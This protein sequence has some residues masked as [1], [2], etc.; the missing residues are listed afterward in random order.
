M[1]SVYLP[2]Q[3]DLETKT[4]EP[5]PILVWALNLGL[6]TLIAMLFYFSS[7]IPVF[8]L[9]W[10][11]RLTGTPESNM[12]IISRVAANVVPTIC[13]ALAL[14]LNLRRANSQDRGLAKLLWLFAVCVFLLALNL[15]AVAKFIRGH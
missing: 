11:G 9:F 13:F 1:N 5:R 15:F 8:N 7:P 3:A 6:F 14:F 12:W 10:S 2:P 4:N